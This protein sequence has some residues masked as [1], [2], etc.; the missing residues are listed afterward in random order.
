M[1]QEL[2]VPGNFLQTEGELIRTKLV[3]LRRIFTFEELLFSLNEPLMEPKSPSTGE[4]EVQVRGGSHLGRYTELEGAGLT[5]DVLVAVGYGGFLRA[6]VGEQRR[7][8]VD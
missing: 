6:G 1:R 8:F 2:Q 4:K 7:Q 5:A 3:L